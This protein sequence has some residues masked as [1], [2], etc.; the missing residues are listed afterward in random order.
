MLQ[1][2]GVD[3]GMVVVDELACDWIGPEIYESTFA[4]RE[5]TSTFFRGV[6]SITWKRYASTLKRAKTKIFNAKAAYDATGASKFIH[7]SYTLI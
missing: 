2:P 1:F 5:A 4:M 3:T 6:L 7:F